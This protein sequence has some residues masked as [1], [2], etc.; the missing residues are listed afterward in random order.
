MDSSLIQAYLKELAQI[1]DECAEF[2]LAH[3][4]VAGR[5]G[6]GSEGSVDPQ[7]RQLIEAVAFIAA[8]VKRNMDGI[9]GELVCSL[10]RLLSPDIVRPVPAMGVVRLT[11]AG[12]DMEMLAF[13]IPAGGSLKARA[14]SEGWCQLAVPGGARLWPLRVDAFWGGEKAGAPDA[15]AG[16]DRKNCFVIRVSAT[17]KAF[18][19][20]QPG[21]LSLFVTGPASRALAAVEALTTG[22]YEIH[23]VAVGGAWSMRL[24]SDVLQ[25]VGFGRCD[26]R[27][28]PAT[29]A[30]EALSSAVIEYLAFPQRF[31][32]FRIDGVNCPVPCKAFDV[33]LVLDP[34]HAKAVDAVRD[35]FV[36]N[37]VPVINLFRRSS[38]SLMLREFQ[39]EY[40]IPADSPQQGP[41]DVYSIDQVRLRGGENS[42]LP[43]YYAS[44]SRAASHPLYWTEFRRERVGL[45]HAYA[46][47]A[48][49]LVDGE[50]GQHGAAWNEGDALRADLSCTNC[51][52]P[53]LLNPG[54][55]IDA[56]GFSPNY[57]ATLE[58]GMSGYVEPLMPA[59]TRLHSLLEA[60]AFRGMGADQTLA[61]VKNFLKIRNR[62]KGAFGNGQIASLRDIE[63]SLVA[64]ARGES[65]A[66][67]PSH[68]AFWPLP[69][70]GVRYDLRFHE[71]A[72]AEAGRYFLGK[73]VKALMELTSELNSTVQ[74]VVHGQGGRCAVLD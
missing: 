11:P 26:E 51:R 41:W 27:L 3:P 5:L 20:G 45:G 50:G 37:C 49:A 24:P 38:G 35:N 68:A 58:V 46:S 17:G 72:S 34:A 57:R 22:V 64:T 4:L 60:V 30:V 21:Q 7:V 59:A 6:L 73:A 33:V 13:D 62:G 15:I 65:A 23:L 67:P 36:A 48:L 19:A 8:R 32:F 47:A 52:L 66:L 71:D 2:A 14:G 61:M 53:E 29:S 69:L 18:R 28:L 10:L 74:V 55:E 1:E 40:L 56:S 16:F 54:Q 39:S 44:V 12:R 63:R 31:C 25:G 43:E 70:V 9:P 42:V